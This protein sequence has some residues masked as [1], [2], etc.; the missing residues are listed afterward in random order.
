LDSSGHIKEGIGGA[1]EI[2]G[3]LEA[4]SPKKRAPETVEPSLTSDSARPAG[5]RYPIAQ[6]NQLPPVDTRVSKGGT[7]E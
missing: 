6:S 7:A 1:S 2:A 3:T 5:I 4:L